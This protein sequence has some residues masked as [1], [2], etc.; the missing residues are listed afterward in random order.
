VAAAEERAFGGTELDEPIDRRAAEAR[1]AE[2][3]GGTWWRC[4]GPAVTVARP[5]AGTRSSSARGA[6][7]RVEIQLTEGQLSIA[8]VAHELAHALAGVEHGHDDDFR[9][10]Y[11]DV[12][13]ALAGAAPAAALSEALAAMGIAAG[14]RRWPPPHRVAGEGFVVVSA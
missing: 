3:T 1:L 2:V 12:V 10:A 11:V 6:T 4:C 14:R 7:D 9:A 13:T 5:R 8:T